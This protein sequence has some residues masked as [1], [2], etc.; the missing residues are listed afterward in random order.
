LNGR[1]RALRVA[2]VL[3]TV[4]KE[5]GDFFS[6]DSKWF[7]IAVHTRKRCGPHCGACRRGRFFWGDTL[8]EKISKLDLQEYDDEGMIC[9]KCNYIIEDADYWDE[10]TNQCIYCALT[11]EEGKID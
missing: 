8:Q 2:K 11:T 10:L 5:D 7:K 3:S 6:E 4:F 9:P 1:K